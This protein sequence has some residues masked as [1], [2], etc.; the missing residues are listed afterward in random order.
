[1][2]YK[3]IPGWHEKKLAETGDCER[4]RMNPGNLSAAADT[5]PRKS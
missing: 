3:K 1:M 4:G 2:I 5:L